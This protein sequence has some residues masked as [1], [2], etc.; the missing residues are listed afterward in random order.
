[1]STMAPAGQLAALLS[2]A[3]CIVVFTGTGVSTESGIP[4]FRSPGGVWSRMKPITFQEFT[5]DPEKR[6]EAW[7]R[8][9]SGATGW[10]GREPNRSHLA[11]AR[12]IHAGRVR[13]GRPPPDLVPSLGHYR[14]RTVASLIG[15][16]R[17]TIWMRG[18]IAASNLLLSI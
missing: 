14:G 1:M 8:V 12:L 4:D 11:I 18:R 3:R 16:C 9:F 10:T 2:E 7:T 15:E 5:R 17:A 13:Q 6:Q